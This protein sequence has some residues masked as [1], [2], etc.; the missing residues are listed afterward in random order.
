MEDILEQH[1][2]TFDYFAPKFREF[3]FKTYLRSKLQGRPDNEFNEVKMRLFGAGFVPYKGRIFQLRPLLDF[4]KLQQLSPGI[5]KE[6]FGDAAFELPSL[7]DVL[8]A[9]KS[10]DNTPETD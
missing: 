2:F 6:V 9:A 8:S 7:E 4:Y 5:E 3:N 10:A 1:Q